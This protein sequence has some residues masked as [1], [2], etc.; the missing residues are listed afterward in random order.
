MCLSL[1]SGEQ[2]SVGKIIKFGT[3]IDLSD[4]KRSVF[5]LKPFQLIQKLTKR[6]LSNSHLIWFLDG[7]HSCRSSW[8]CQRSCVW[9]P[10]T[11]C[12]VMLAT[13]SWAWTRFSSTWRCLAV[14]RQVSVHLTREAWVVLWFM[15]WS[16][17]GYISMNELSV[18]I[19]HQDIKRTTISV[20]STSTSAQVTVSGLLCMSTTGKLSTNSVRSE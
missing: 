1:F 15:R 6:P 4:P 5:V 9:N 11:I 10:A 12:S 17:E 7:S 8:S 16:N 3:N 14:A 13:P 18:C 19:Y 2:K 20:R